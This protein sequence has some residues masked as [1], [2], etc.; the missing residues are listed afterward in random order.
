MIEGIVEDPKNLDCAH[1]PDS[2]TTENIVQEEDEVLMMLEG[3]ITDLQKNSLKITKL[4]EKKIQ[5]NPRLMMKARYN[6]R[7]KKESAEEGKIGNINSVRKLP[8]TSKHLMM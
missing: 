1:A 4:E 6:S 8:K 5:K 2:E 7:I 3:I